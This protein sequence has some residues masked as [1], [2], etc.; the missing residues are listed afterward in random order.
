M[1][2]LIV[3]QYFWPENFRINE[4]CEEF[5]NL[6]HNITILTGYP[7]Y[8][9]G[10]IYQEFLKDKKK[11]NQY[12]GAKII[13]VPLFP[14]KKNKINLSLNYI[15]FLF[16][17]IL[18][19][20]FNL[21]NENFDIIFT[22]QLS[23]VTVG[24]TSAFF[25]KL[26]KC[27]SVL[28]TLDLWPD[29][30]VALKIIKKDW[31]I[32]FL[33]LLVNWIYSNCDVILAQ[34]KSM[35]KEIRKYPSVTNN[36][37]YFPSWSESDLFQ[38]KSKLAPEIKNKIIFTFLFAGNIGEAQD[39]LSIIKAVK[40]LSKK[41][42]K[43]FRI[44]IIGEGSKKSWF[45]NEIKKQEIDK[46]FELLSS[47]PIGRMPSFFQHADALIIS[48]LD[49]EVFN[50]TIPGKIQFYLTS[51][52]PIVG[53]ISGEGAK[54]IKNSKGGLICESGDYI[55]FSKVMEKFINLDKKTLK[56]MGKNGKEYAKKEFSKNDLIKKLEKIFIKLSK[57][58]NLR[59]KKKDL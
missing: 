55:N 13:R 18:L 11:F 32:Y 36:A 48:L 38:R 42:I 8:P 56:Q 54:V 53:M 24:I 5:T 14:R 16:N 1:K 34:S 43:N 2:I 41:D 28:W 33:K 30:L 29:T 31:Q 25:S 22:F 23:P 19:G 15:S 12:K 51:G 40:I 35:L 57:D 39:F 3:T 45:K 20:Y 7:N 26:N 17:S 58:N 49:R 27:P 10:E 47:Y 44:I 37:Y 21:K 9:L 50:I 59:N 46:Y 6:G 52:I 4:L